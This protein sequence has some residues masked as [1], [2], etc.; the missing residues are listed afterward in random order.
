MDYSCR[1]AVNYGVGHRCGS[2]P[3]LLWL[4]PRPAATASI[5]LL[6]WETPY[7][8]GAAL[9]RKKKRISSSGKPRQQYSHT[10]THTTHTHRAGGPKCLRS[11][12]LIS[13]NKGKLPLDPKWTHSEIHTQNSERESTQSM[14]RNNVYMLN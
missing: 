13:H 12:S 11:L 8:I 14:L 9:K 4:W 5:R 2:D 1:I 10:H 6:A 3:V 7:A